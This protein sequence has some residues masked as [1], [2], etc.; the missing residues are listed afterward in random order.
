MTHLIRILALL[1]IAVPVRADM[2]TIEGFA[3]DRTEVSIAKFQKFAKAAGFVSQA[4]CS[5]GGEVYE[6]GREKKPGWTWQR[7]FGGES[8]PRLPAVHLTFHEATAYCAWHGARLPA[9]IEWQQAAYIEYRPDAS[10]DFLQGQ[11][12]PYPMGDSPLGGELFFGM[13]VYSADELS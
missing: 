1:M 4:E 11:D 10:P 13:W 6:W 9:E 12:Y 7:P 3:I 5:G 8:D 2:Q